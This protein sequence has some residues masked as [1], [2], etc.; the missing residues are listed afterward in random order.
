MLSFSFLFCTI[1]TTVLVR[2]NDSQER[3]SSF[4]KLPSFHSSDTLASPGQLQQ[5]QDQTTERSTDGKSNEHVMRH[6]T[7]LLTALS[8]KNTLT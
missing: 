8:F 7:G 5:V 4:E 1:S 6:V 2:E 3:K